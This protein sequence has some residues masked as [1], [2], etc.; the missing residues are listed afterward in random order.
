MNKTKL[1]CRIKKEGTGADTFVV[2]KGMESNDDEMSIVGYG[3][4]ST[5][6]RDGE[7]IEPG[8][9]R[10]DNYKKNPVLLFAHKYDVP[11]VGKTLWVKSGPDGLRFK[12]KFASTERGKEMYQLYKEGV[13]GAFSV[14]F[15]PSPGGYV[16][17]PTDPKYKGLKRV[18]KDIE[19]LEISCVPIPANADALVEF[20]KS[21]K[22]KDQIIKDGLEEF[23]KDIKIE[24]ESVKDLDIEG[25][26]IETTDN[27]IH[28]PV[29]TE[30]GKHK[31]H[32]IRTIEI[33][34]EDGIK[35]KYCADDKTV[36]SYMFD[37]KKYNVEDAKKWVEERKKDFEVEKDELESDGHLLFKDNSYA[38]NSEID[39]LEYHKNIE[40]EESK[41]PTEDKV[42]GK[43]YGDSDKCN[44]CSLASECQAKTSGNSVTVKID[45]SV[46]QSIVDDLKE[47]IKDLKLKVENV[48]IT[49]T[50]NAEGLPSIVDITSAINK[51]LYK[52]SDEYEPGNY[53]S[54]ILLPYSWIVDIYP[55]NYPNG[56]VV[57]CEKDDD[58]FCKVNY[59]Y[60]ITTGEVTFTSTP[61]KVIRSWVMDKYGVDEDEIKSFTK[62][63][64]VLS[65]ANRKLITDLKSKITEV[66]G[67]LDGLLKM[68]EPRQKP[69]TKDLDEEEKDFDEDDFVEITEE[70]EIDLESIEMKEEEFE[71]NEAV[72]A[73]A[74][75]S[76]ANNFIEKLDVKQIISD[77]IRVATGK[78]L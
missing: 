25:Q 26:K 40:S 66:G 48:E 73:E 53:N 59:E 39:D 77:S 2:C 72:L 49:K 9:W 28:V 63:G 42:F 44:S 52:L 16:D 30:E 54:S 45:T 58:K 14:G 15:N 4:K 10:L 46:F 12:A 3:S 62:E 74:L 29:S 34:K 68:S 22:V 18:Y 37:S 56:S 55:T 47:Q 60:D 67:M 23:I 64:R 33:S 24:D 6:D 8:A 5:P 20:I 19:L 65:D 17:Q 51:D 78:V 11:P 71:I 21:G 1:E 43:D 35:G 61:E 31:D 13:L 69:T 27:Y 76:V 50:A 57:Y 7:L 75:T 36:I 32:K 38:V 70:K 41:C